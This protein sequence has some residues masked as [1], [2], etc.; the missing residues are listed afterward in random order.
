MRPIHFLFA[1]LAACTTTA[2]ETA[3]QETDT[4]ETDTPTTTQT[5][6]C[7]VPV[8]LLALA[9]PNGFDADPD[10]GAGS[11]SV[12]GLDTSTGYDVCSGLWHAEEAAGDALAPPEVDQHDCYGR[13]AG[14]QW[15]LPAD[16]GLEPEQADDEVVIAGE[17]VARD[18][19]VAHANG[20]CEGL[21]A[22]RSDAVLLVVPTDLLE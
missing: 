15:S 16:C 9:C 2:S 4:Q 20:R 17:V 22:V 1:S 11:I 5:D 10:Y 6:P 12:D 19:G 21:T 18:A 7:W 8:P 14:D 3:T 13:A